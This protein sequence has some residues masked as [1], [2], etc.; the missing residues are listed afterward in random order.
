LVSRLYEQAGTSQP[1]PPGT[2]V[3]PN[4]AVDITTS[5]PKLKLP[6]SKTFLWIGAAA[7]A[8][9]FALGYFFL[10]PIAGSGDSPARDGHLGGLRDGADR[11]GVCGACTG[12]KRRSYSAG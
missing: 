5:A 2:S 12:A 1:L 3:L 9:L 4:T 10:M 11:T 6:K 7:V 8:V